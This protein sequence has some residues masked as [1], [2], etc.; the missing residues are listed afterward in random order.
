M[1]PEA[2]DAADHP[3]QALFYKL[4][5]ACFIGS[6][7]SGLVEHDLDALCIALAIMS[8]TFFSLFTVIHLR[9]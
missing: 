6:V 1:A 7:V 8:A 3:T 5:F 4:G 2:K 9:H